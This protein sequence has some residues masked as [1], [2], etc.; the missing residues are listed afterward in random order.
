MKSGNIFTC[1]KYRDPIFFLILIKKHLKNQENIKI[2]RK[3][4]RKIDSNSFLLE[5]IAKKL[6]KSTL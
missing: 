3:F 2:I 5:L 6:N 1:D 4:Q